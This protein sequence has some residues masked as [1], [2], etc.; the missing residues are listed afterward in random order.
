MLGPENPK[1][2]DFGTQS[3]LPWSPSS[4]FV[5]KWTPWSHWI[6]PTNKKTHPLLSPL[7]LGTHSRGFFS[8]P[9]PGSAR[10]RTLSWWR[11]GDGTDGS[12]SDGRATDDVTST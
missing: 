1:Q 8:E 5:Q 10:K 11:G 3:R 4:T 6:R 7:S 9:T 2:I 12:L